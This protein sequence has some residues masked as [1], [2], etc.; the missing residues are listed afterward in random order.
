MLRSGNDLIGHELEA[1]DGDIGK[2]E[3]VYFDDSEWTVRYLVVNTGSWLA[4]R[5]VLISPIAL[6]SA[7]AN[8]RGIHVALTT[9]QIKNSPD[10]DTDQPVSKQT[11]IDYY[12]YYGWPYWGLGSGL[13]GI[14]P[15]PVADSPDAEMSPDEQGKDYHLRSLEEVTGYHIE[16]TDHELGHVEDFIVATPAGRSDTW[17]STPK[18]YGSAR[19]PLSH[20]SQS[21]VSTGASAPSRL[22]CPAM[23]SNTLPSGMGKS[24]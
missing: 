23:R 21:S 24:R 10:I 6:G 13:W 14:G 12:T 1:I 22:P 11:E 5:R 9:E 3:D 19:R 15:Y 7:P 20:P 2:V 8:T 4:G 16:A 18:H 17:W